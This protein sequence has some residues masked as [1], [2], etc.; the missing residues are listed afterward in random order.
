MAQWEWAAFRPFR[1]VR[2]FASVKTRSMRVCRGD[3]LASDQVAACVIVSQS[4]AGHLA[5][6]QMK[7]YGAAGRAKLTRVPIVFLTG[8]DPVELGFVDSFNRPGRNLTGVSTL[9]VNS[10][11]SD[12][13][14]YANWCRTPPRLR[15]S[16]TR[17]TG[18]TP[19][20]RKSWRPLRAQVASKLSWSRLPPTATS[21]QPLRRSDNSTPMP[22][23]S[24]PT[25][26]STVESDKLWSWWDAMP[27]RR[28]LCG[29]SSSRRAPS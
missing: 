21:T 4:S 5:T 23:W 25:R 9:N 8:R 22:S 17:T 26:F 6:W 27:S 3:G 13:S 11:R 14:F 12:W 28:S 1:T 10:T 24:S 19:R 7:R 18:I 2:T 29:V 20:T 15:Y 16:S